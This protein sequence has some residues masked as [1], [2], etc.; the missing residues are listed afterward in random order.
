[1][2]DRRAWNLA[3]EFTIE[4]AQPRLAELVCCRL[5]AGELEMI[6]LIG[7]TSN[8]E[9]ER[10]RDSLARLGRGIVIVPA[11]RPLDGGMEFA[12]RADLA[13]TRRRHGQTIAVAQGVSCGPSGGKRPWQS[14]R[15]RAIHARQSDTAT[16]R[17]REVAQ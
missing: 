10:L 14:R 5:I 11:G 6:V 3:G 4:L 1:M 8:R 15:R 9:I 13:Q 16:A 12:R 17:K 2:S 7:A